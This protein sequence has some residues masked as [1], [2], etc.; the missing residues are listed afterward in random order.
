[1]LKFKIQN[2]KVNKTKNKWQIISS[3]IVHKNPHF[4]VRKDRLLTSE[5]RE[6]D[7]YYVDIF[8]Y[9]GIIPLTKKQEIYLVGQYRPVIKEYFWEIPEGGIEEKESERDAAKRELA[10]EVGL[11]AG[12][13]TK[14]GTA[15]PSNG[16]S[17]ACGHYYLAQN[18][19]KENNFHAD[20][21][22]ILKVKKIKVPH[23]KK[24]VFDGKIKD[25]PTITAL[26]F[27]EKFLKKNG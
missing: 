22:E 8:P 9:V 20:E 2:S 4:N 17:N 18:L 3:K 24:M 10:E 26:F 1:M 7:Y 19:T 16:H 13:L 12:K 6:N 5:K 11:K 23:L 15:F 25:G 27:L 21:D 14:I